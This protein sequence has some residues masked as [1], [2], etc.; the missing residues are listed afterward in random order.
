MGRILIFPPRYPPYRGGSSTYFSQLLNSLQGYDF[1]AVTFYHP[2]API[3]SSDGNCTVYRV[4]P[5]FESLPAV[6]RVLIE[7]SIAFLMASLVCLRE[8]VNVAHVHAA[9][10]ATPGFTLAALLGSMPIIYDCRDE[11][12]PPPLVKIGRT[13]VWF[14]CGSNIDSILMENGIPADK[15]VRVPV[16]N[17]PYVSEYA[18][19]GTN[20]MHS[21]NESFTIVFIGRLLKNKG[22]HLLIESFAEFVAHHPDVQ[23]T[24]VGDDLNDTAVRLVEKYEL[25]DNVN[26][27]GEIPHRAA[28]EQLAEA[29]VLVLPSTSE[30]MPRVIIEAFELGVPV[31]ATC[32]GDIPKLISH[33]ETGLLIEP[34]SDS[35]THALSRVY[36]DP[37][38]REELSQNA[39]EKHRS[40]NWETVKTRV[41]D[42]Y[43]SVINIHNE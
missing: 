27:V 11:M 9:S 42:S 24:L 32:V 34:T 39:K 23:L 17:P 35:I 4:I 16:I 5:K 30:G 20:H 19:N 2:D 18:T 6:L 7:A 26:L 10:F 14:S 41:T 31:V 21:E 43:K 38:L 37:T 8:S 36:S 22:V 3:V 12:F 33:G 28:I 13:P 1:I 25:S 40:R 29:D 15:I